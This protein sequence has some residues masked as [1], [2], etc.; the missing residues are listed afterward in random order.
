M[1]T[2]E[3]RRMLSGH[4]DEANGLYSFTSPENNSDLL[5]VSSSNDWTVRFWTFKEERSLTVLQHN[6]TQL[7]K[8]RVSEVAI[9]LETEESKPVFITGCTNGSIYGWSLGDDLE[10]DLG[11]IADVHRDQVT[12]L[13]LYHPKHCVSSL[14]PAAKSD[15]MKSSRSFAALEKPLVISG[16]RDNVIHVRDLFTGEAVG[17]RLVGHSDAITSVVVYSGGH[18]RHGGPMAPFIA[19]SSED[20]DIRLWSL[21]SRVCLAIIQDHD[22]DVTSLAIYAPLDG[23]NS[24]AVPPSSAITRGSKVDDVSQ[25]QSLLESSST[26]VLASSGNSV[27]KLPPLMHTFSQTKSPAAKKK[28]KSVRKKAAH[29]SSYAYQQPITHSNP[30][31]SLLGSSVSHFPEELLIPEEENPDR[32][33]LVSASMD[34]TVRLYSPDGDS[35]H[36]LAVEKVF[37]SFVTVMNSSEFPL[38]AAS[39]LSGQVYVWGLEDPYP[40]LHVFSDH[41]DEVRA[42]SLLLT[43]SR[44]PVLMSGSWDTTIRVYNLN[45]FRHTKTIEGQRHEITAIAATSYGGNEPIIASASSDG[46]V[47]IYF[48]F[49]S[50]AANKDVV[51]IAFDFDIRS[52]RSD[53]SIDESW[54]RISGLVKSMGPKSFFIQHY[55]LFFKAICND[56]AS[57]LVKFLHIS[58]SVLLKTNISANGSLLYVAMQYRDVTAVREIVKC[59]ISFLTKIPRD[60][61]SLIYYDNAQISKDDLLLLSFLYPEEFEL[62]ISSLVLIPVPNNDELRVGT[63]YLNGDKMYLGIIED[64]EVKSGKASPRG[65]MKANAVAPVFQHSE[66]IKDGLQTLRQKGTGGVI[67]DRNSTTSSNELLASKQVKKHKYYFLPLPGLVDINMLRAYTITARSLDSFKIFDSIAGKMCQRFVW[68]V[69]GRVLH[70]KLFKRYIMYVFFSSLSIYIFPF[71]IERQKY[72]PLIGV[73]LG[74]QIMY[75]MYYIYSERRQFMDHPLDYLKDVWNR[76]DALIIVSG[77]TGNIIRLVTSGDTLAS[78]VSLSI[79]SISLWYVCVMYVL[80]GTKIY[81]LMNSFMF[82]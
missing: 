80:L 31:K 60:S 34:G 44:L 52:A 50:S 43:P 8:T 7:S 71:C 14:T 24:N 1:T 58:H 57:F 9:Y 20:N 11:W 30:V 3:L 66:V 64:P 36:V 23:K 68:R 62:L 21:E 48:D 15:Y 70:V 79:F 76:L 33:V 28:N 51:M 17:D 53:D 18:H 42:L 12:S 54:P 40:C 41:T 10:G 29:F 37:F 4:T 27:S 81:E 61:H 77:L 75:D 45:T 49:L 78:R 35:L 16:G 22:F 6:T 2:G 65:R 59:W 82:C 55:E 63:K 72:W 32:V 46:T 19:S 39:T 56:Q 74:G 13:A 73:L 69:H 25:V 5:V 67:V 26:E 47:N 38:M